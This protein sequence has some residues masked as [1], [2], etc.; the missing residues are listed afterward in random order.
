MS[1][2][3]LP[4]GWTEVRLADVCSINPRDRHPDDDL[5]VT[6]VPMAAVD[7]TTGAIE[8]PEV[9]KV[10][11]V[12]RGFTPFRENDVIFAKITPCMENGKS[13]VARSLLNGRGYGS[14]EFVVLRAKDSLL[15]SYLHRFLRQESYRRAARETMQSGVGQARVPKEF[16][17][18]SVLPLPP[19]SE[20]RRIVA[21]LD[22]L[23]TSRKS[24]E[25]ALAAIPELLSTLRTSVLVAA[26]RG[27]LTAAWRSANRD[28]HPAADLLAIIRSDRELRQ[29]K[30]I[31]PATE[32]AD[33]V[34]GLGL[35]ALP[36]GWCWARLMDIA[37]IGTG[38]TPK[39]GNVRYWEGGTVPWVTSG[40]ANL[41][42]VTE[43]TA[44]V[45][46]AALAECNLT[47]YDPGTLLI[48][49]Y[50]EGKTRGLCTELGIRACTNQALAA[51]ELDPQAELYRS[52]VRAYLLLAYA[53]TRESAAGGV[54][55]NLNLGHIRN[56]RIPLAPKEETL[57]L[58]EAVDRVLR[59]FGILTSELHDMRTELSTLTQTILARAFRGE[60]VEQD[61]A[62]PPAT[63]LL[64]A[65]TQSTA[66]PEPGRRSRH[67]LPT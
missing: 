4:E 50:G 3:D 42:L 1:A 37:R 29:V 15:P 61:P 44:L 34:T 26:F 16:I 8:R 21:R 2:G 60:L 36:P 66:Q 48:A 6:F 17:E 35:S 52:Y 64:N 47:M 10:G 54:Q 49:M 43:P 32:A 33:G 24:A 22:E 51:V 23:D 63:T 65:Q 11:E 45:T 13:A 14:T 40:A 12:R 41:S 30:A 59:T 27:E 9:R 5:E 38:A 56:I 67:V 25:E 62:D 18:G 31:E 58:M 7:E 55:P 28:V 19:S 53:R 20:Q 57:Q 39:R 46:S